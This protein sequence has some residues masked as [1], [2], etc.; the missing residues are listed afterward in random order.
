MLQEIK[1]HVMD[2]LVND[3]VICELKARDVVNEVWKSQVLSHL[4]LTNN[5]LGYLLNFHVTLMKNG[6]T[7]IIR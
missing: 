5:R 6:I 7:R 3:L 2:V 1:L 4:K